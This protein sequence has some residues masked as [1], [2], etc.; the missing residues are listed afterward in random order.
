V[1]EL[2]AGALVLSEANPATPESRPSSNIKLTQRMP[3]TVYTTRM[4][5]EADLRQEKQTVAAQAR[6]VIDIFHEISTLLV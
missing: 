5:S 6:Q 3:N 2:K 4:P 1:N